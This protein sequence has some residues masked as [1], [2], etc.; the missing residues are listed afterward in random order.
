MRRAVS[1]AAPLAYQH[2]LMI[3]PMTR[4]AC[5]HTRSNTQA[6]TET[7]AQTS[8]QRSRYLI[9]LP[10][11]G[12]VGPEF[13]VTHHSPH[14]L[15][16]G[17]GG[18]EV[19]VWKLVLL[20]DTCR[21]HGRPALSGGFPEQSRTVCGVTSCVAAACDLPVDQAQRVNV[22]TLE[23]IKVFHV[24]ALIQNLR[25]HIPATGQQ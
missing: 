25:S 13:L 4:R 10:P 15:Y 12:H 22:R 5:A 21:E 24:D 1:L 23:G 6:D 16:G 18:H 8:L 7:R 11:V 14:L 17:V 19:V 3:F 9:A 2:S 20:V